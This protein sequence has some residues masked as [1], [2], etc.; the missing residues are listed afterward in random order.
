MNPND[1][2]AISMALHLK[3]KYNA[4]LIAISMAPLTGKKV[5]EDVIGM[6]IDEAYLVSDK[7]FAGSDTLATSY[8]LAKTIEKVIQNYTLIL[9]GEESIDGMTA[10]IPAQVASWLDIPY[11][12]YVT[13]ISIDVE[14]DIALIERLIDD[15]SLVETYRV[16][17]PAIF[18]IHKRY[19]L[20]RINI[21][22][23]RK[24][25]SR[26][27]GRIKVISNRELGLSK[28]CVGIEGS[29][30]IVT[31]IDYMP[32][33]KR[34]REIFKGNPDEAARWLY[35]RIISELKI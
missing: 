18:S 8:V 32:E 21:S 5:F 3:K 10:H 24:I 4:K 14:K 27:E 31:D 26:V 35:T 25:R 12:Y 30:T 23:A 28:D 6:G 7:L 33:P 34:K 20:R 9:T 2:P 22:I 19:N 13:S 16:K 1:L 15:E 29:P 11:V 17:L